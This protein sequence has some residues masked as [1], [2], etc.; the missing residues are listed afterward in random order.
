MK[1]H[2]IF[3]ELIKKPYSTGKKIV[4]WFVIAIGLFV[5]LIALWLVYEFQGRT[6]NYSK[7]MKNTSQ[8]Y[9]ERNQKIG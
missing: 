5:S 6:Q 8:K 1:S 3:F 9:I 7:Q 2:S 4:E